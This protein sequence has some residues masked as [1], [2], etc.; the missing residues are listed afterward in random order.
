MSDDNSKE[1]DSGH[2]KLRSRTVPVKENLEIFNALKQRRV[3]RRSVKESTPLKT[4][5]FPPQRLI[6]SDPEI[7]DDDSDVGNANFSDSEL[8]NFKLNLSDL[9]VN[10]RYISLE[11]LA[12]ESVPLTLENLNK[13]LDSVNLKINQ[14]FQS[15]RQKNNSD[16]D[17]SEER[18]LEIIEPESIDKAGP[19]TKRSVLESSFKRLKLVPKQNKPS[20]LD[21]LNFS[22]YSVNN[23]LGSVINKSIVPL[24]NKAKM[25]ATFDVNGFHKSIPEY[26]GS[27]DELNHFLACCDLYYV[28]LTAPADQ[29][30]FVLSLVRKLK[31][32]AFD[33][34]NKA[35]RTSWPDLKVA[36]KKYFS[37]S[38]S[39][40]GHQMELANIKQNKLSVKEFGEKI[41]KILIE[42]NRF[43][44]EIVVNN[45]SGEAYFRL[46]NE[47]L[48][49][50][51]F[52]NGINEPLKTILRARAFTSMQEAI[53]AAIELEAEE[54]LN[55]MYNLS[56]NEP[57]SQ[58]QSQNQNQNNS[59]NGM[60]NN[61]NN[62]N[63]NNNNSRSLTCFKCGKVG[64][65][66]N[67]CYSR[68][69]SNNNYGNNR[70][71]GNNFRSN[72]NNNLGQNQNNNNNNN[73]QRIPT[74]FKCGKSGH[75]A[76]KCFSKI[77]GQQNQNQG[78][79]NQ[80]QGQQYQGYNQNQRFNQNNQTGYN[81]QPQQQYNNNNNYNRN[82]ANQQPGQQPNQQASPRFNQAPNQANK[83]ANVRFCESPKN[84]CTQEVPLDS[85][86]LDFLLA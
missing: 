56:M 35:P 57:K 16:S 65:T 84:E 72:Y 46:Q 11:N 58:T 64:H 81:N 7:T 62:N 76:N 36:L 2:R 70:A 20:P 28:T 61:R 45:V 50:K 19:S 71:F 73:S 77:Q 26:S 8:D 5:D 10:N 31:G 54:L 66:A 25:A 68:I 85:T 47:K 69:N 34:Y 52:V 21:S 17:S 53:T 63:N 82:Q 42:M 9:D 75:Y 15:F 74:C 22:D 49:I 78:Q 3:K 39:F 24:K 86:S 44:S 51:A 37:S 6:Y 48:A 1:V 33:F 67:R 83:P 55:K 18:V 80:N 27:E 40:E 79:Q 23:F 13:S 59:F 41:E 12:R 38:K 43:G 30:R 4:Q 29:T 14:S 32:R 60:N